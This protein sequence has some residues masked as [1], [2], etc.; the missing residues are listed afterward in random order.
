MATRG[1][2]YRKALEKIGEQRK[3]PIDRAL[4]KLKEIAYGKFDETVRVDL[5]LGVDPG[6]TE[7]TVRGA[8]NY[9]HGL[10]RRLRVLVFAKGEYADQ[11]KGAGADFVGVEEFV[12]KIQ[13]GWLDFEVAVSTPDLMGV[14]GQLAKILGPRGLL[15]N[16]KVGTVTF[17]VADVVK[18]LKSGKSFFKND[19]AGLIHMPIGKLS[20]EP[21][22]LH[23]NFAAL[24]KAVVLVR[25]AS[26][27]GR[28]I[29]RTTISSTM[30]PGIEVDVDSAFKV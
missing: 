4:A 18:E 22:K 15:P 11:A 25:P 24:L 10:G 17:D 30:S 8:V 6:K 13:G 1:K 3:L 12:A 26:A 5:T 2:K 14:I 16:K 28:F 23:D 27:K 9:P 20:F 7:Q 29:K 19:R 21:Q